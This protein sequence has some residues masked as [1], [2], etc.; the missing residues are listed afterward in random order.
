MLTIC[1]AA[2]PYE[3]KYVFSGRLINEDAYLSTGDGRVGSYTFVYIA[4]R[5]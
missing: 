4:Q 1:L 2:S 5:R 3:Q